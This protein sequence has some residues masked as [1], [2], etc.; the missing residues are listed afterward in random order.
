MGI[1]NS[2]ALFLLCIIQDYFLYENVRLIT[3]KIRFITF[4]RIKNYLKSARNNV[5]LCIGHFPV[6]LGSTRT[7]GGQR[8]HLCS[9]PRSIMWSQS[10]LVPF[11]FP[12]QCHIKRCIKFATSLDAVKSSQLLKMT[13]ASHIVGKKKNRS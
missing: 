8:F 12:N 6:C 3:Q 2:R 11:A 4:H 7:G 13:S 1:F 5:S 9:S 10:T